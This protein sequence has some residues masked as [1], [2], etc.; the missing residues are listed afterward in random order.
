[1]AEVATGEGR[2]R[3]R[4]V[5]VLAA[6]LGTRMKSEL[7][8]ALHRL[9][10]QPLLAYALRTALA[11]EPRRL[12][13]VAGYREE[14]VREV[15]QGWPVE[16]VSQPQQ[17]GT[18]HAATAACQRLDPFDGSVAI[19][20]GDAPFLKPSTLDRAFAEHLRSSAVATVVTGIVDDPTGLGRILRDLPAGEGHPRGEL[21]VLRFRP[22]SAGPSTR[23]DNTGEQSAGVLPDRRGGSFG[24]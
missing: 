20:V 14:L 12:L 7:P 2:G 24:K 3:P 10:R 21:R 11:L 4:A 22:A 19:T 5:I 15:F 18:G 16:W 23:A 8:K 1:M 6:G 13:V 9:C 17:L